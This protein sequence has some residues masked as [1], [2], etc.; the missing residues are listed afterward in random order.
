MQY[1]FIDDVTPLFLYFSMV[2]GKNV[3][4]LI[5]I[6]NGITVKRLPKTGYTV[7]LKIDMILPL[8]NFTKP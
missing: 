5:H 7:E 1:F 4:L 8:Q 2:G 3:H 6:A